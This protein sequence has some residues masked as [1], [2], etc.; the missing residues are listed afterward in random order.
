MRI[1]VI[2][3][4]P[5][6]LRAYQRLLRNYEVVCCDAPDAL[7]ILDQDTNFDVVFCDLEMSPLHGWEIYQAIE[8]TSPGLARRF[9]FC[10]GGAMD[11]RSQRFIDAREYVLYKPFRKAELF[12]FVDAVIA[13]ERAIA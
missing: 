12:S 3:D 10:T 7:Q 4:D 1:L 5:I 11:A 2:D 6:L 13:E 8:E 9:V